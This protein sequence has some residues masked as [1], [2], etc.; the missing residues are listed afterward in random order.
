VLLAEGFEGALRCR[1]AGLQNFKAN[2][3]FRSLLTDLVCWCG[4]GQ[5]HGPVFLGTCGGGAK[6]QLTARVVRDQDS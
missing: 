1:R 2:L 6:G 4:V 3:E 5:V